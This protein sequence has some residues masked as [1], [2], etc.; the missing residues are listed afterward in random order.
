MPGAEEKGKGELVSKGYRVSVGEDGKV[1][2]VG[3]G[4]GWTTMCI[5]FRPQ[6]YTLKMIKMISFT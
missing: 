2:E 1:L 5:H 4:N 6:N 3:G